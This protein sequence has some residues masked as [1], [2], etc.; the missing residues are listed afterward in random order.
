MKRGYLI[1]TCSGISPLGPSAKVKTAVRKALKEVKFPPERHL[2]KIEQFFSS[3]FGLSSGSL[4]HAQSLREL[5][6]LIPHVFRPLKVMVIGPSLS[7]YEEASSAAGAETVYITADETVN[8]EP[9]PAEVREKIGGVGL[10]F[11]SE[12]N[13][14]TGSC[15]DRKILDEIISLAVSTGIKVVF[16]ESLIDFIGDDEFSRYN[17]ESD[18]II[19][20]RTTAFF[21]GMPGLEF[22]YAASSPTVISAMKRY[23]HGMINHL[24]FEGARAALRDLTYKRETRNYIRSEKTMIYKKIEGI[25]ELRLHASD[26]NMLLMKVNYPLTALVETMER[27]GFAINGCRNIEGLN[28]SFLRF[29]VMSHDKNHKFLRILVRGLEIGIAK[30]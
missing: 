29:S 13:R 26:C 24:A 2:H 9:D 18:N 22:A 28:G 4:L 27:E 7:I 12:P 23:Y 25:K 10:L 1:D 3:K 5:I 30:G 16:D 15:M 20:L 11:I 6:F 17:Y 8:F 21:Y 14:V 19:I